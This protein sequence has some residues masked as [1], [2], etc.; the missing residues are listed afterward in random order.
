MTEFLRISAHDW[1]GK[2]LSE[3]AGIIR[4]LNEHPFW[5][6]D[7]ECSDAGKPEAVVI[8][9]KQ[10]VHKLLEEDELRTGAP[11]PAKCH[12]FPKAEI[13]E[14][15]MLQVC[16]DWGMEQIGEN[17]YFWVLTE[18]NKREGASYA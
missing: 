1:S 14:A 18:A 3:L 15:D 12:F 13:S 10:L 7:L 17:N 5:T 6:F 9:S 2:S 4:G 8:G 16:E 11:G